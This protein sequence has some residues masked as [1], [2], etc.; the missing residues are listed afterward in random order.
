ME[1]ALSGVRVLDL[2]RYLAG[3][4]GAML[5]ADL[6]AEVIRVESPGFTFQHPA[7]YSYKGQDAYYISIHRN[8]RS[9]LLDLKKPQGQQVFYDLV[10]VSD[11]VF[12]NYR[13]DVAERLKIDYETLRRINPRIICCSITGFGTTGPYR[14]RPAYD[15]TIQALSGAMSITGEAGRPPVRNGVATGDLS[16][17][18]FAAQGIL[19]AL[20]ARERTGLG[21]K[22]DIALLA[23]QIALLSYEASCY[24]VSGEVPGPV[25]AGHRT[26]YPYDAF[27]CQDDYIVVAAMDRFDKL[28]QVLGREDLARDPRFQSTTALLEHKAELEPVLKEIFLTKHAKEWLRL[29]VAG[30]VPCAPI[31][32]FDQVFAD[33]QVLELEMVTSIDHVLGGQV[34]VLG[35]PIRMSAT[36]PETR[37]RY[38][39]PP[40]TGQH[41]DEVLGQI[42]G[43]SPARIEELRQNG[44]V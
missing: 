43:Y 27:R 13:P 10:K 41:T 4:F 8:K 9:I 11:V 35:N 14:D 42:L 12:D 39:S 25:G 22:I 23:T 33:P 28:C 15:L 37:R 40:V 31:N 19:A 30:D 1:T 29:L 16:G 2:T 20:Y 21:Q 32:D 44:V 24:F 26:I 6:G 34:R 5:L 18:M 38:L 3:P 17:G 36:P 7:R